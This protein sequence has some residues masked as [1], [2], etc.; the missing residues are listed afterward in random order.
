MREVHN[1][2]RLVLMAGALIVLMIVALMVFLVGS[3]WFLSVAFRISAL[4]G[5]ACL[6]VPF[7][8]LVFLVTHWNETKKPFLLSVAGGILLFVPIALAPSATDTSE[9]KARADTTPTPPPVPKPAWLSAERDAASAP[10]AGVES[11]AI[12]P[13]SNGT[14]PPGLLPSPPPQAT[15]L[16]FTIPP[17]KLTEHL[18]EVVRLRMRDGRTIKGSL[19]SVEEDMIT[20]ERGIGGGSTTFPIHRE[21]VD[22]VERRHR[23]W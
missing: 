21:S 16:F 18:G 6:F 13:V 20:L 3:L 23:R 2:R 8:S 17:D 14:P 7:A 1:T 19:Y 5:L 9:E 22:H 11:A 4:W 12:S 10:T 15:P